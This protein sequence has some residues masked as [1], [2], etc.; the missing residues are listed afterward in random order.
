MTDCPV[1]VVGILL[2]IIIRSVCCGYSCCCC[3][4]VV[5][6]QLYGLQTC[7]AKLQLGGHSESTNLIFSFFLFIFLSFFSSHLVGGSAA[8]GLGLPYLAISSVTDQFQRLIWMLMISI[9]LLC[10]TKSDLPLKFQP[11]PPDTFC[12]IL[13]GN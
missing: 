5:V 3:C 1:V 6:V 4:K 7:A 2:G 12:I 13:L 9:H 10:W 11:N 8:F